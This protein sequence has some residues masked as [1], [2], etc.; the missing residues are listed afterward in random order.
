VWKDASELRRSGRLLQF[1]HEVRCPV[2][3][4]HGDY[5]PHPFEGV[6]DP[7]GRAVRDFRFIFLEKCGREPWTEREARDRFYDVLKRELGSADPF[8]SGNP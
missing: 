6:R 3:A 2:V 1:A 7:L 8:T 5:D 4:I